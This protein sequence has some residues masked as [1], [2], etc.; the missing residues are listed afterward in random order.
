MSRLTSLIARFCAPTVNYH[1]CFKQVPADVAAVDS[2]TPDVL[3]QQ[4]ESL[5]RH[6]RF[7]PVDEFLHARS[8]SRVA[9]VT[10][11]DGY[12][13]VIDTALPVFE[14]LDIPFTV[15]VNTRPLEGE[16]FWRHKVTAIMSMGLA[17]ECAASMRSV[18]KEPGQSFYG[19]L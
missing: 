16:V 2:I 10:W 15:F 5:K 4:L 1:A 11:D 19:N 7:V 17:A 8:L 12:K 3:H 9:A 18:Y 6:F 13:S 14:A